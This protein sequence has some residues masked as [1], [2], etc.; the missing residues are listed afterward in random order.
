M[1]KTVI[2]GIIFKL[3][4]NCFTVSVSAVQRH[5][6]ALRILKSPPWV[7]LSHPPQKLLK[8]KNI[9]MKSL[10]KNHMAQIW[11]FSHSEIRIWGA[12]GFVNVRATS[13]CSWEYCFLG[14]LYI[15]KN[16]LFISCYCKWNHFTFLISFSHWLFLTTFSF[17]G[18]LVPRLGVEPGPWW[19][20]QV[21]TT[22]PPGSSLPGTFRTSIW[23][24]TLKVL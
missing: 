19:R 9:Y 8:Q 3:A 13:E 23:N 14:N 7:S 22:G 17:W 1:S 2:M 15:L 20:H 21:L 12:E 16:V 24:V 18:I 4:H 11:L 6:S 5:E 10:K